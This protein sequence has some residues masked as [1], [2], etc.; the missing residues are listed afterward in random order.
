MHEGRLVFAQ[1]PGRYPIQRFSH[2]DQ[3]LCMAFAQLTGSIIPL[4]SP[5]LVPEVSAEELVR[6][7][8]RA[9]AECDPIER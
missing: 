9:G 3:F 1:Y 5:Q 8:L 2:L 7:R 4:D 6:L